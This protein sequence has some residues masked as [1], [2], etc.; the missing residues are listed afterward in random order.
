MTR[1]LLLA[2]LLL[3]LPAC[4]GRCC[5]SHAAA[6]P[7]PAAP[8]ALGPPPGHDRIRVGDEVIDLPRAGSGYAAMP[9]Q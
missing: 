5:P 1:L 8:A 9:S 6:R 7:T 4:H 2:C 3:V